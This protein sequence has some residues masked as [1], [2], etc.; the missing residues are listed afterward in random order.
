[1]CQAQIAWIPGLQLHRG[2]VPV[3]SSL[4]WVLPQLHPV[5][6]ALSGPGIPRVCCTHPAHTGQENRR[7]LPH[8]EIPEIPVDH[9]VLPHYRLTQHPQGP[10]FPTLQ[11]FLSASSLLLL[12]NL[13]RARVRPVLPS[14]G[15]HVLSWTVQGFGF[16]LK[17]CLVGPFLQFWS[18]FSF[19]RICSPVQAQ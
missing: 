15:V 5:P 16:G 13:G 10:S 11:L 8:L 7:A 3:P 4:L 19:P 6:A 2:H 9:K 18:G 12:P 17:L 1:M 14:Q